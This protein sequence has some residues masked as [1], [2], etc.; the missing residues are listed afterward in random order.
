MVYSQFVEAVRATPFVPFDICVSDGRVIPVS[1]P[2]HVFLPPNKRMTVI[3]NE[4]GGITFLDTL[5][6][7][8]LQFR[9]MVSAGPD[10][11]SAT[12]SSPVA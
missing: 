6:V 2:E 3:T 7:T 8:E 5:S 10:S 1:N 12:G 4:K 11:E 9:A